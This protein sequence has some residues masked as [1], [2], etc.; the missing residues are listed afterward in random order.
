MSIV[1]TGA[2]GHLGRLVVA[3]LL[4]RG[5]IYTQLIAAQVVVD[6]TLLYTPNSN[7]E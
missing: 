5:G 6:V 1:V 3:D 7:S 2:T 4:A